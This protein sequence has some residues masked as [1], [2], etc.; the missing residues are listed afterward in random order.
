MH[1]TEI[2]DLTVAEDCICLESIL[3]IC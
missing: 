2:V 3:T 1:V